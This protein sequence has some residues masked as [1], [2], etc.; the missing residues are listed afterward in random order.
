MKAER[1]VVTV[2]FGE[3][4]DTVSFLTQ[5]IGS[6]PYDR[7]GEVYPVSS[8]KNEYTYS[9]KLFG[10]QQFAYAFNGGPS[11]QFFLFPGDSVHLAFNSEALLAGDSAR[12]VVFSGGHAAAN[13]QVNAWSRYIYS[14]VYRPWNYGLE[15]KPFM[16]EFQTALKQLQG[17]LDAFAKRSGM[18]PEVKEWASRDIM[19]ALASTVERAPSGMTSILEDKLF[20]IS[21]AANL[22][23]QM[24]QMGMND[25]L[26][27][28]MSDARASLGVSASPDDLARAMV[29]KIMTLP[30]GDVRDY[31]LYIFTEGVIAGGNQEALYK[32]VPGLEDCIGRPEV[33]ALL[34]EAARD[35]T[36]SRSDDVKLDQIV[37][38]DN[39]TPRTVVLDTLFFGF[40]QKKYPGQA[41][42]V[43]CWS[44]FCEACAYEME[45]AALLQRQLEEEHLPV[46][47]V[48]CCVQSGY[49]EWLEQARRSPV[50]ALQCY[51]DQRAERKLD[52]KYA[53][54]TY[55]FY[56][57]VTPDG[58][59]MADNLPAPSAPGKLLEMIR[60]L[61]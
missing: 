21:D 36:F 54:D 33:R 51:M 32:A 35:Y 55:P 37:W 42:L 23:S 4:P 57:L 34:G 9:G 20:S 50:K 27:S 26:G 24:F 8:T 46:T 61:F 56:I 13:E 40:L 10:V 58:K 38:L 53:P 29:R 28:I 31:L 41:L 59:I 19:F 49:E 1:S 18:L 7:V 52:A 22:S 43:D 25:Y 12:F 60:E 39:D 30:A 16:R 14:K 11:V 6:T 47:F 17:R 2:S 15:A 44:A 48:N 45:S 5:L 3:L